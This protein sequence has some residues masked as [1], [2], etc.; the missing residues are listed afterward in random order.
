MSYEI[1]QGI[2]VPERQ[3]NRR[4]RKDSQY[5][6]AKMIVGDSFLVP[7]EV[8]DGEMLAEQQRLTAKRLGSAAWCWAKSKKNGVKFKV[9]QRPEESGVRIWRIE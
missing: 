6:F 5:P 8:M 4:G 2:P 9:R 7:V 3:W 1:Q